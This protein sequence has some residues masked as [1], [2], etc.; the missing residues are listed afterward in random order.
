MDD[1]S[2]YV[3]TQD[4]YHKRIHAFEWLL[5]YKTNM[6]DKID[7]HGEEIDDLSNGIN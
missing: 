3:S 6:M 4:S 7:K 2:K 5:L 1:I